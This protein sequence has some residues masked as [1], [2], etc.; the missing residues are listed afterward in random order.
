MFRRNKTE[1]LESLL[2]ESLPFVVLH[3]RSGDSMS[4]A[5]YQQSLR[6]VRS[7]YLPQ[8]RDRISSLVP[9]LE[10]D[11][12]RG[13]LL[14][15]L[16][17]EM[18]DYQNEGRVRSAGDI[19]RRYGPEG[20]PIDLVLRNLLRRAVADGELNSARAFADCISSSSCTVSEFFALPGLQVNDTLVIF[21][22]VQLVP[23]SSDPNQLPAYLPKDDI[24]PIFVRRPGE[25]GNG[26][27]WVRTLLRADY[28]VS[29][30]FLKASKIIS[31][32]ADSHA[33]FDTSLRSR[34]LQEIE[35]PTFFQ[36]LSMVCQR[37]IQPLLIWR[38]FIEPYEIFDL[39]S[40]IGPKRVEW[41][42]ITDFQ[43]YAPVL[44][45]SD[46][47]ELQDLYWG[48]VRLAPENR[49]RLQVPINRWIA[50]VGQRHEVDRMIDLG[51][52]FDSL[53]LED[54]ERGS[55]GEKLADRASR[56]LSNNKTE[57]QKLYGHFKRIYNNRSGA[58]HRGAL[59]E[60]TTLQEKED[61]IRDAQ[62]LCLHTIKIAI[63]R[64]I[65]Q[66]SKEWETWKA[67][68]S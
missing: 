65:P 55:L 64:G 48:I 68:G 50:S 26:I 25:V 40:L 63:A 58:V 42:F 41:N 23:L 33:L 36:A 4:T 60:G 57:R 1:E 67:V 19:L 6:S 44:V 27:P 12:L 35:W 61:F 59:R 51:I 62:S 21:D 14:N 8:L 38:T 31:Q 18:M 17:T 43:S 52:A 29:P 20:A 49:A 28:D 22:G 56:Y 47:E 11:R 45:K 13:A 46:I 54:D 24:Y 3:S 32:E 16:T 37:P 2:R 15:L 34:D 7:N 53:Y 30:I 5:D 10:D 66:N 39:D 9:E